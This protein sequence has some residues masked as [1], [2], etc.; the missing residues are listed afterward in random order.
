MRRALNGVLGVATF[1]FLAGIASA[2]M[3]GVRWVPA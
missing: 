2:Q 3:A 1:L